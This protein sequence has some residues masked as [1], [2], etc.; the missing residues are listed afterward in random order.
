M[1]HEYKLLLHTI[2]KFIVDF[3][4]TEKPELNADKDTA[5]GSQGLYWARTALPYT[6][7]MK[8]HA[9]Y[10][11]SMLSPQSCQKVALLQDGAPG[12]GSNQKRLI[13]HV[14]WLFLRSKL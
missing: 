13:V 1:S 6:H 12:P 3:T 7:G 5:T 4:S 9:V 11:S 10:R 14:I 2:R 8:Q